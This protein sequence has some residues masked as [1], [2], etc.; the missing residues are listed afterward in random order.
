MLWVVT[1]VAQVAVGFHVVFFVLRDHVEL[2]V[3]VA[4]GVPLGFSLSSLLFFL[5]SAFLGMNFL[6]LSIH[7]AVLL[8]ASLFLAKKTEFHKRLSRFLH[9]SRSMLIFLSISI[10]LAVVIVPPSILQAPGH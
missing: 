3:Q 6:H 7:T 10:I 9:P 4:I 8:L 2:F 1:V 5:V